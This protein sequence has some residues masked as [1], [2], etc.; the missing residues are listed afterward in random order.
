VPRNRVRQHAAEVAAAALVHRR[1]GTG[2]LLSGALCA[3][4]PRIRITA[5]IAGEER[6]LTAGLP[7]Y[8]AYARGKA[9]LIPLVW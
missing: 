5:R 2:S 8:R 7:G 4:V 9:R 6:E 3:L 1:L